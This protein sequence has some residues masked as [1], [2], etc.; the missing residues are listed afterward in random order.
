MMMKKF[1]SQDG[2]LFQVSEVVQVDK[3]LWVH[4]IKVKTEEK[5]SCLIE[6]FSE[7]FKPTEE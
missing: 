1:K 5:Y 7:R 4:Y 6:A 3:E 2:Q